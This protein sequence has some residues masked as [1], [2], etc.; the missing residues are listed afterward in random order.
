MA[1]LCH[2][3]ARLYDGGVPLAQAFR[4]L[5]DTGE[6]RAMTRIARDLRIALESGA[7]LAQAVHF[8]RA[9]LAPLFVHT[10]DIAERTGVLGAVLPYLAGYYD[11][12]LRLR[13]AVMVQA[14]YPAAVIVGILVGIPILQAF[15][16]DAAGLSNE[17]FEVQAFWILLRFALQAGA[18]FIVFTV[19]ARLTFRFT[20]RESLLMHAWPVA[21]I[22]RRMLLARF[23][24]AMSVFTGVGFPLH[25]AVPLAGKATGAHRIARDFAAV[26]PMLQQG[27][28]LAEALQR[29]RFFPP[30]ILAYVHTA[31]TAGTLDD[32]FDKIARD[33]YDESI[34]RLRILVVLVEPLA[35]IAIGLFVA[36]RLL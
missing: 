18:V 30:K 35:I 7:T 5:E 24:W 1:R 31:E 4:A 12:M 26:A 9:R 13:R 11:D 22:V 15:L 16:S 34:F 32:C 14:A 27:A 29:A 17:S 21:P 33:L 20:T 2:C 6:G 3:L 25:R 8:H 36:L 10:I 19:I 28:T 23:V